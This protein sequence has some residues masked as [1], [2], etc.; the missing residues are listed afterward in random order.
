VG[1]LAHACRTKKQDKFERPQKKTGGI[2]FIEEQVNSNSDSLEHLHSILQLGTRT[3]KFLIIVKV[4]GVPIEMEV[5]S[6]AE[7][8]TIPLS[9]FKQKLACVCKLQSSTVS[10]YQYDK[11]PLVVAGECYAKITINQCVI[12]AT[13][14]VVDV[15][16]QPPLL[17]RDWMALL[18][19]D[20]STL[21]NQATQI[22]HNSKDILATGIMVEFS[23]V[24]KDQL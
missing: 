7:R 6:G 4:N 23:D 9:M 18:Q 10:L 20:V 22:H 13:F 14:V 12:Q 15:Q 5:D 21:M 24:F 3:N 8:S 2:R 19:F 16:K 11:S 17:G 1:H